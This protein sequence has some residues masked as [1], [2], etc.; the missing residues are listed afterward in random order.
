M[1]QE[2]FAFSRI[3]PPSSESER[4]DLPTQRVTLPLFD[5]GSHLCSVPTGVLLTHSIL[6][7]LSAS[8]ALQFLLTEKQQRKG[9]GIHAR[10]QT[11]SQKNE[12]KSKNDGGSSAGRPNCEA[13]VQQPDYLEGEQTSKVLCLILSGVPCKKLSCVQKSKASFYIAKE[14][15]IDLFQ[16]SFIFCP[17]KVLMYFGASQG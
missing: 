12:Q 9:G 15:A 14:N 1:K 3:S 17:W 5:R 8:P 4:P 11:V 6:S 13:G 10:N 7:Q 2:P 16:L